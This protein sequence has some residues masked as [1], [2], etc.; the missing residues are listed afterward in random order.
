MYKKHS[1]YV[2][3]YSGDVRTTSVVNGRA[4]QINPMPP[5]Q[6]HII[7]LFFADAKVG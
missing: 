1:F 5:Q 6:K 4:P 2:F 3:N 7:Y